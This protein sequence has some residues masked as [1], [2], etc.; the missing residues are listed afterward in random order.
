MSRDPRY[1]ILFEPV[2]IGPVTTKNRFYQ[3]PHCSGTSDNAPDANTR[4]REMKA[5]GGWGVVC[6]EIAEIGNATEFWPFPSL[7]LWNDADIKRIS[8]MPEAVHRH[9]ALAGVELGHVGLAAGNRASRTPP[10]GPTSRLTLESVEPFQSKMMD[11]QDIRT[12]REQHIA[13]AVRAQKAGFDIV[14]AYAGHG[15]SIFSQ[16]LQPSYNTRTDEYGGSLENRARLLR[17]VLEGMKDAIGDSCAVAFRF[18]VNEIDGDLTQG[19]E[20]VEMLKDI[21]DLWDVNISDWPEDSQTSRFS[22]EGFQE[23]Q[24]AFVKGVV[25][26]PVVSVG[27]FTSPDTMLS[28]VRRGV[29]DLVGAARPSIADPFIPTKIDQGR[30]DDIRECIGCNICASGEMSYAPM[31]CTQNPTIMDEYRRGWHPEKVPAKGSED[32]ILIVGGGP[33][34]LECA[35]ILSRRGYEVTLA[36]A[37]GELGGRVKREAG[38]P[39]LSEWIRVADYRLYALQQLGNVN[40]Y[41]D[42]PLAAG[43]ILE[44]GLEHVVIATGATWRR[45]GVGRFNVTPVLKG[46]EVNVLTPDDILDEA[47]VKG[48]VVIY[49]EDGAY[50]GNVLAEKL[51]KDGHAV[52]YVVPASEVAPYLALTM[53]QH[54]VIAR[55]MELGVRIERLKTLRNVHQDCIEFACIHG[56]QGLELPLGTAVVLT[57]KTPNDELYQDLL[58][59][60]ADWA[61]AGIKSVSRIG[62]CEAP[63]TIAAAVHAG[64]RWA[65]ELDNSDSLKASA[66]LPMPLA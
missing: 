17:E 20:L 45:D 42:S 33:A 65:R 5:E 54:K 13:A 38:L 62:D 55:L 35:N 25:D 52:S 29:L 11:K 34:G 22:K 21:P 16:F 15:L 7:H 23:Q 49:D 36:D 27:R 47:E 26:K 39:D 32:T 8:R 4:M 37:R 19:Q 56:G 31:R 43:D 50:L 6:T 51:V 24:V 58:E 60:E 63:S 10:L 2:K 57:S 44:F 48:P 59:R 64:H 14:Y 12:V 9:G 66:Y 53:E 3:V 40:L 61:A 28:Q 18:G 1:D 41:T 30:V 46:D